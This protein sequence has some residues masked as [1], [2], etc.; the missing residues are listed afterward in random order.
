MAL[1]SKCTRPL[2]FQNFY[3]SWECRALAAEASSSK[4]QILKS[5]FVRNDRIY[6]IFKAPNASIIYLHVSIYIQYIRSFRM[7]LRSAHMASKKCVCACVRVCVCVCMCV[8]VCV[9]ACV[10]ACVC[11]CVCACVYRVARHVAVVAKLVFNL[12]RDDGAAVGVQVFAHA[13]EQGAPPGRHCCDVDRLVGAGTK[14]SKVSTRT[15]TFKV[16]MQIAFENLCRR[17]MP[18]SASSQA[19]KPPN[20]H[21]AQ[22]Y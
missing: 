10:C 3:F 4:A 15:F 22:M 14:F 7:Y 13:C 9:C 21:S 19:G 8:C 11:V 12:H 5:P 20:S 6:E 1:C 18:S 16:T 2:T 17:R